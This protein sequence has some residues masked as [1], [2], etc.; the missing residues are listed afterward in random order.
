MLK[1]IKTYEQK[2]LAPSDLKKGSGSG[3]ESAWAA[4]EWLRSGLYVYINARSYFHFRLVSC[5]GNV[6]DKNIFEETHDTMGS[7]W[8]PGL[9]HLPARA[10][11]LPK[12]PMDSKLQSPAQ[13]AGA[14]KIPRKA[15]QEAWRARHLATKAEGTDKAPR[16]AKEKARDN[17]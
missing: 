14:G 10:T 9:S 5:F 6:C 15:A 1:I 4:A 17:C 13:A 16:A 11:V 2:L 12:A 3:P 7:G 8:P